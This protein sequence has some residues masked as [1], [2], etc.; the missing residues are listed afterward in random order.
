[1]WCSID[2]GCSR[3]FVGDMV[4]RYDMR[5]VEVNV[6]CDGVVCGLMVVGVWS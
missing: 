4:G 6:Q 5:V 2:E 1:M 3:I